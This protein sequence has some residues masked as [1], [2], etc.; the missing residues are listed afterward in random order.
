[1]NSSTGKRARRPG[2]PVTVEIEDIAAPATFSHLP[3][4]IAALWQALRVLPL[5][6]NQYEAYRHFLG[7]G[8]AERIEESIERDGELSLTFRMAGRLHSV[9]VRPAG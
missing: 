4:A 7:T 8:A 1:V 3:D 9:W 2:G 5:G 6:W